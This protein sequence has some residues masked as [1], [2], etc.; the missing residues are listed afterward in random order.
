MKLPQIIS[1]QAKGESLQGVS[2]LIF[3]LGV[4]SGTKNR[5]PIIFPKTDR[6]GVAYLTCDEFRDQFKDHWKE[7]LMDYNG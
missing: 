7:G 4:T 5:Y 3:E 6:S 2:G 1:I